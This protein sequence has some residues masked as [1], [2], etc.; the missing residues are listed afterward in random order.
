MALGAENFWQ[1][2]TDIQEYSNDIKVQADCNNIT[3]VNDG[4]VMFKVNNKTV[5]P[6]QTFVIPANAMEWNSTQFQ[7]VF[8]QKQVSGCLAVVI[9]SVYVRNPSSELYQRLYKENVLR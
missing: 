9:R 3:F 4:T 5:Q 6:G 7:I 2:V 8:S 1:I